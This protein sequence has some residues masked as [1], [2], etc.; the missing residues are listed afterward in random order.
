MYPYFTN[1]SSGE[2]SQIMTKLIVNSAA[3]V[4]IVTIPISLELR[5]GMACLG[6]DLGAKTRLSSPTASRNVGRDHKIPTCLCTRLRRIDSLI[7][8]SWVADRKY[9][10]LTII[11]CQLETCGSDHCRK[12]HQKRLSAPSHWLLDKLSGAYAPRPSPGPHKLRDCMPLIVF[13]RNR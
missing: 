2:E 10:I 13:I 6:S 5:V 1:R 9:H 12:K 3:L 8:Q 4:T 11:A 7:S